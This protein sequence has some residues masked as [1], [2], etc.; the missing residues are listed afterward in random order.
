MSQINPTFYIRTSKTNKKGESAIYLRLSKGQDRKELS[1]GAFC[2]PEL[3][4]SDLVGITS[5]KPL[6]KKGN[7]KLKE[8]KDKLEQY[9]STVDVA[10]Q[11]L[12]GLVAF[13]KGKDIRV[14]SVLE[15]FDH[16]ISVIGKLKG[17]GYEPTTIQKYKTTKMHFQEAIASASNSG[18]RRFFGRKDI[19]LKQFSVEDIQ[20]FDSYLVS[21]RGCC[22]NTTNK[23]LRCLRAVIKE[24]YRM[25]LLEKD[26]FQK[27]SIK[28]QS[29]DPVFLTEEEVKRIAEIDLKISRLENARD[30]FLL[31][32][33]TGLSYS[34]IKNLEWD[35]IETNEGMYLI[36][37]PRV[38]TKVPFIVPIS[39]SA[40]EI[41]MK[42]RGFQDAL[43]G[44]VIHVISNQ[45]QNEYLKE[46][47]EKAGIPKKI[48]MHVAR[49]TFATLALNNEVPIEVVSKMI[50]HSTIK[51]TQ[52]YARIQ[53]GRI[54]KSVNSINW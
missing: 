31:A 44:K 36:Q 5:N 53:T 28:D 24:A 30:V 2:P 26:P 10:S 35:D 19:A 33:R 41:L 3:W 50:G 54:S 39:P 22:R 43:N 52:H 45:K 23:Y 25:D 51:H 6:H 7:R 12:E 40:M 20:M 38:K 11:S 48:T 14:S 29:K 9:T 27:I 34:D 18:I 1:T 4:S 37:K 16:R 47:A 42:Y 15:F 46:I 13:I 49:H 8:L 21:E 32:C 17:K